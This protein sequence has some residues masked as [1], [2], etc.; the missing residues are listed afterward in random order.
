MCI[1]VSSVEPTVFTKNR[2]VK[3]VKRVRGPFL[4]SAGGPKVGLQFS[5]NFSF[6]ILTQQ[7]EVGY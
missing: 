4:K 5:R 6:E 3:N 2:E 1:T 7:R